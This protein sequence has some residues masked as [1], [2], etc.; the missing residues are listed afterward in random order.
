MLRIKKE[1]LMPSINMMTKVIGFEVKLAI[2]IVALVLV[3]KACGS[4][5]NEK[6]I[7]ALGPEPQRVFEV[8][9]KGGMSTAASAQL[10]LLKGE[11][12]QEVARKVNVYSDEFEIKTADAVVK[13]SMSEFEAISAAKL[14]CLHALDKYE[15]YQKAKE[16]LEESG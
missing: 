15:A 8:D 14:A 16:K 5:K 9:C 11:I 3:A 7:K 1:L 10:A 4:P 2:L 12:T 13:A 6:L